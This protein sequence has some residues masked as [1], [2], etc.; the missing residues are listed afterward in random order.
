[1]GRHLNRAPGRPIPM[2]TPNLNGFCGPSGE[3]SEIFVVLGSA[4]QTHQGSMLHE[5]VKAHPKIS[6]RRIELSFEDFQHRK[7]RKLKTK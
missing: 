5:V 3:F 6:F 7:M 4:L 2:P 1:M